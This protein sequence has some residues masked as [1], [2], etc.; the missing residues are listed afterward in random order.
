MPDDD[1]VAWNHRYKAVDVIKTQ[2]RSGIVSFTPSEYNTDGPISMSASLLMPY[3]IGHTTFEVSEAPTKDPN[4]LSYVYFTFLFLGVFGGCFILSALA[5]KL[6]CSKKR[7][8]GATTIDENKNIDDD[9]AVRM[10]TEKEDND[11]DFDDI[12]GNTVTNAAASD[13]DARTAKTDSDVVSDDDTRTVNGDENDSSTS[14]N[15]GENDSIPTA[16]D[17]EEETHRD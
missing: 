7:A 5:N 6:F 14:S 11:F 3:S 9:K 17:N 1:N 8:A 15:D 16:N 13:D 4:G 10:M 2:G 12:E